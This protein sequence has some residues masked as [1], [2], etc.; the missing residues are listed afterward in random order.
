MPLLLAGALVAGLPAAALRAQN[1]LLLQTEDGRV[2]PVVDVRDLAAYVNVNGRE[3]SKRGRFQLHPAPVYADA[4][5]RLR[6]PQISSSGVI[7]NG[8]GTVVNNRI[9]LAGIFTA[10][11]GL[12]TSFLAFEGLD[13]N[14]HPQSLGVVSLPRLP[15]GIP[16]PVHVSIAVT[17]IPDQ[18]NYQLHVF[19]GMHE[20]RL[21]QGVT[22]DFSSFTTVSDDQRN[23]ADRSPRPYLLIAPA[24]PAALKA[25]GPAGKV[26]LHC[27]V[28]ADGT[29]LAAAVLQADRPEFGL[30]AQDA[31]NQWL[32]QPAV[33]GHRY[34]PIEVNIPVNF[35]AQPKPA[36]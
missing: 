4:T 31:V 22:V 27:T 32:F 23:S 30:A 26:L 20:C 34:V 10:T 35:H 28:G 2:S 1:V 16:V 12:G 17:G 14:D 6:N 24:Y 21:L 19:T 13:A 15:S 33:Q 7:I 9:E 8:G 3:V 25:Q 18:Q 5:V 36:G 11:P 29:M